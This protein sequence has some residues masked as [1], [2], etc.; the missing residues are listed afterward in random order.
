MFMISK[1]RDSPPFISY[2]MIPEVVMQF[3][4]VNPRQEGNA[5]VLFW[6]MH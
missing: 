3:I 1:S 6:G 5:Q 4:L 2:S